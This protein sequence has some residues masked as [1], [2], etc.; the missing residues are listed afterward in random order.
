MAFNPYKAPQII[1]P[2]GGFQLKAFLLGA[3]VLVSLFCLFLFP[4]VWWGRLLLVVMVF[5]SAYYYLRLHV[6]RDLKRSVIRAV[7]DAENKWEIML[8]DH[9]VHKVSLHASSF[10][11]PFLYVLNFKMAN[12]RFYTLLFF[13]DAI[14]TD[15]ARRLRV[16]LTLAKT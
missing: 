16:R 8:A 1:E 7:I 4:V 12:G 10:I 2:E 14:S 11:S 15:A 3:H 13:P 6:L 9:S 5:A